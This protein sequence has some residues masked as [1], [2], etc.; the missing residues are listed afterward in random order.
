MKNIKGAKPNRE[1]R[2]A[3]E[4]YQ[5]KRARRYSEITKELTDAEKNY[6]GNV[7]FSI[8]NMVLERI[9]F[10]GYTDTMDVLRTFYKGLYPFMR[11]LT[12]KNMYYKEIMQEPLV[13]KFLQDNGY[14][15]EEEFNPIVDSPDDPF[16]ECKKI[17]E[18]IREEAKKGIKSSIIKPKHN[19]ITR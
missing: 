7:D 18:K 1:E 19:I 11:S 12:A 5:R 2:R 4:S 13:K 6:E 17:L 3:T 8:F 14:I 10:Q 9:P 15:E 16:T